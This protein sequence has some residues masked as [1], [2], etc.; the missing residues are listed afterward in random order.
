LTLEEVQS[1]VMSFADRYVAS[2]VDASDRAA[3]A[4]ASPELTLFALRNKSDTALAAYTIASGPNPVVAL[5]DMTVLVSLKR[6][7]MDDH[8]LGVFGGEALRP[9]AEVYT[10][11][12]ADIW[13]LARE[14]LDEAQA[15]DLR[16]LIAQ[17]RRD[18]PEQRFVN[19]VRFSNFDIYRNRAPVAASR[20]PRSI[21]ALLFVDP[22]ANLDPTTRELARLREMTERE[23]YFFE[24]LP[25]VLTFMTAHAVSDYID[26]PRIRELLDEIG[27][28]TAATDRFASSAEAI[29]AQVSAAE[30]GLVSRLG[31]E[32]AAQ[33]EAAVEHLAGVVEAQRR[34]L[35]DDVARLIERERRAIAGELESQGEQAG[36]LLRDV[37]ETSAAVNELATSVREVIGA[38]ERLGASTRPEA[39]AP[40]AR[41][42]DV[43]EYQAA[44][45]SLSHAARDIRAAIESLDATLARRADLPLEST[46]IGAAAERFDASLD[47]AI[48]AAFYRLLALLAIA[49]LGV[50][51]IRLWTARR[52][53]ASA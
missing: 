24:R 37:R 43:R 48:N 11:S 20:G 2:V 45:E 38:A 16:G 29:A 52:G 46:A 47:A 49:L 8:W 9:V 32:A 44:A 1:A 33:R 42:F 18:N 17:W 19:S 4:A 23:A 12:E 21:F 35:V 5:L 40:P 51:V 13:L 22:L 27:R 34:A 30:G 53:S 25:Q 28:F 26:Q 3:D 41:P 6:I 31:V 15:A 36:A 7:V 50:A 39:G 14:L 10:R